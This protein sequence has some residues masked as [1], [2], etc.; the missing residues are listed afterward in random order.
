M[1]G[2]HAGVIAPLRAK[3]IIVQGV[4]AVRGLE[5][6]SWRLLYGFSFTSPGVSA[7]KR[8]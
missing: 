6:R 1:D 2:A 7:T 5:A 8:R 4:L 3:H